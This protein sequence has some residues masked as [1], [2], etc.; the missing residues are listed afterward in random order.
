MKRRPGLWLALTA[1]VAGASMLG[2][3]GCGSSSSSSSGGGGSGGSEA[4]PAHQ[5][6]GIVKVALAGNID[7]LDPALAYYQ[8]TW[9]IEYSTCVKLTNYKDEAGDAGRVIY[10]EAASACRTSPPT[11]SPTPTRCRPAGSSSTP[12]SRSP[13]IV[14]ARAGARPQPQAGLVLRSV[15]LAP[16]IEGASDYKGK[17]GEHVS[18]IEVQ[19][20][21]LI[22]HLVK[23][24]AGLISKLTTPFA[25]AVTK[26]T[27][28][29]A[30]GV[31]DARRRRPLL[32]R[33]VQ[34]EPL[35]RAEEEP[36]LDD[37]AAQRPAY[38]DEIDYAR[39]P[40]TDQGTLQIKNGELDYSPDALSPAQYF[41]LNKEFGPERHLGQPAAVLHHP[42]AVV[43][44]LAPEHDQAGLLEPAGSPGG[45]L[46]DRPPGIA[47]PPATAPAPRRTSTCRRSSRQPAS[48]SGLPGRLESTST[49]PRR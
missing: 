39:S 22:I 7:Y 48:R 8:S 44:Y 40:R 18:G 9:Q 32:H 4:I 49:R 42:A 28:V 10:P 47:Q 12:A 3:A 46:R 30:K 15:F 37:A 24:D 26:D 17:P 16:V 19:G 45:Q 5:D 35:D 27:P 36:Q 21:K 25:C 1:L 38:L 43:S 33:V 23:Q 13:R 29:D 31:H 20:D 6:G 2:L 34:A 14:P 11:A 41:Q